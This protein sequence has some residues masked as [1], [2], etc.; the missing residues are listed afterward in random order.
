MRKIS[1]FNF[2]TLN[3]FF[4]GDQGDISWHQHGGEE[5]DFAGDAAN[6]EQPNALMFGRITYQMM[7]SFWPTEAGKQMNPRVSEGM[8]RSEK[9]VFSRTLTSADWG[10]T[11]IISGDIVK[12]TIRLKEST[13][14]NITILGSGSIVSQLASNGLIDTFSLMLD[15]VVL[16]SGTSL[17]NGIPGKMDLRLIRSKAF[18]SG[19]LL[20]EYEVKK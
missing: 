17:F 4:K 19:V 14:P 1:V 18:K 2:L 3:G 11:K 9:F 5:A 6:P 20:V 8:N 13:G 12:E 16:G 7:A 15:P 10:G